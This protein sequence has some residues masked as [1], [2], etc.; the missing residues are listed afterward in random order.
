[1]YNNNYNLA[2]AHPL[3]FI[4]SYYDLQRRGLYS[5]CDIIALTNSLTRLYSKYCSNSVESCSALNDTATP[6]LPVEYMVSK[7]LIK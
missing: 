5:C 2:G 1:M 4:E 6:L 3:R 7:Q